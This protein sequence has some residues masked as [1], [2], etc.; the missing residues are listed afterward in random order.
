F[1]CHDP[2]D[3]AW[4]EPDERG[5]PTLAHLADGPIGPISIDHSQCNRRGYDGQPYLRLAALYRRDSPMN[6]L[7]TWLGASLVVAGLIAPASARAVSV[8]YGELLKRIPEHANAMVLVDVDGLLNS[9][10]GQREKWRDRAASRPT[11]VLGV[12]TDA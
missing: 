3:V 4:G 12:S 1:R 11:G 8:K 10:L 9:P 6:R 5:L 2:R 7:R